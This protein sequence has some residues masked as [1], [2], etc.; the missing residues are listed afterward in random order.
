M[1]TK[2]EKIRQILKEG[3]AKS[4]IGFLAYLNAIARLCIK[5]GIFT[6]EEFLKEKDSAHNEAEM[7]FIK[8]QYESEK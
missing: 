4:Q 1:K 3:W 8:K 2:D 5:R 6:E 7:E